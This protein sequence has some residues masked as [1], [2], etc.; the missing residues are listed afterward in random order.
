MDV[1]MPKMDGIMA[2]AEIKRRWPVIEVVAVTSFLEEEKI[3]AAL[4]AGATG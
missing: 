2:T 1:L 4:E 3:R